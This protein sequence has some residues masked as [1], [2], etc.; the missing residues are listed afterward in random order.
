[1]SIPAPKPK[2]LDRFTSSFSFS[3]G[4]W[5]WTGNIEKQG[6]GRFKVANKWR[7]AHKVSYSWF[8]GDIASGLM[9]CHRCDNPTCVRP[10]HLFLG[11]AAA[12][13]A[14]MKAKGRAPNLGKAFAKGKLSPAQV[15]EIR[16]SPKSS[17]ALANKFNISPRN[18]RDIKRRRSWAWLPDIAR[19]PESQ[20]KETER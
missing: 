3:N 8:R 19:P 5:F 14:D 13:S 12:N 11:T 20:L 4:C 16:A 6:Y 18:I 17:Y 1:M 10:D 7:R 9:V 2:D 15:I